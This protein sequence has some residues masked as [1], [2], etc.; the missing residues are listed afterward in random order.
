M[1]GEG[2]EDGGVAMNVHTARRVLAEPL[3][4]GDSKQL[5]AKD[6]V[7][8]HTTALKLARQCRIE[9]EACSGEG[10]TPC[11]Y[12]GHTLPCG[13]CEGTGWEHDPVPDVQAAAKDEFDGEKRLKNLIQMLQ[14]ELEAE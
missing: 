13:A 8:F 7:E 11:K 1:G 2:V 10:K 14:A 5:E 4:F 3:V 9:C 6:L 12:C